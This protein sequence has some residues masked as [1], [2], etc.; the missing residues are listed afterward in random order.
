[1]PLMF[2]AVIKQIGV[3]NTRSKFFSYII[4]AFYG[5]YMTQTTTKQTNDRGNAR[6]CRK[7]IRFETS[8]TVRLYNF[9]IDK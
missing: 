6:M 7:D 9:L 2:N 8:W 4:C 1:M 3:S 5:E